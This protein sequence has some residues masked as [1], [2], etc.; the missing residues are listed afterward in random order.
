[1]QY[2]ITFV[3]TMPI[4]DANMNYFLLLQNRPLIDEEDD[5]C[6]F[7]VIDLAKKTQKFTLWV[8]ESE[9]GHRTCVLSDRYPDDTSKALQAAIENKISQFDNVFDAEFL[10]D[11]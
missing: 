6:V 8:Y 5:L 7:L 4:H 9:S 3:A 1:M 11:I 2:L 10:V